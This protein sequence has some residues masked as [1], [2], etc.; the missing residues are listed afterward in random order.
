MQDTAC[1][2]VAK[3][4]PYEDADDLARFAHHLAN[5]LWIDKLRSN[6]RR[7]TDATA[8]ID[9]ASVD[10]SEVTI[11]AL[12]ARRAWE[13]LRPADRATFLAASVAGDAREYVRRSRARRRLAF[14]LASLQGWLAWLWRRA[15]DFRPWQREVEV[16][17][18]VVAVSVVF[19]G[20]TRSFVRPTTQLPIPKAHA[21][22]SA[23]VQT[24]GVSIAATSRAASVTTGV[25]RGYRPYI[26]T[27]PPGSLVVGPTRIERRP[28]ES[29]DPILCFLDPPLI[30]P[31]CVGD[32]TKLLPPR[33]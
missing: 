5:H 17:L 10:E 22:V 16:V 25:T 19:L 8:E 1:K 13:M 20:T 32:A 11:E 12:T 23:D 3:A 29:G 26:S 28:T 14:I 6:T 7:K 9:S 15:R 30:S 18:A 4:V 24:T 21:T 2:I 27:G 33:R 31:F